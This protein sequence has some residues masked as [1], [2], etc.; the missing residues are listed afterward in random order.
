MVDEPS[1]Q[2][3][4][5]GRIIQAASILKE[6]GVVAFPTETSYGLAA[7]IDNEEALRR[8]FLIKKRS[9]GKPLLV[10][11][12]T[13]MAL[14]LV[15]RDIPETARILMERYWPGPLTLLLPAREG[16]PFAICGDT[17]KVGVRISSH[18]MAQALVE[19]VGR[20]ITATSANIS[21]HGPGCSAEEVAAQLTNPP[22]DF[23]LDGGRVCKDHCSTIV[24]VCVRPIQVIRKGA[25]DPEDILS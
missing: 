24:D 3:N 15:A 12:S 4:G 7:T 20:P 6:G 21:G 2:G 9:P 11:I 19:A 8:V 25:I 10:L 16:L 14:D 22:P 23:I 17:G 1:G 18:P 13:I 5:A